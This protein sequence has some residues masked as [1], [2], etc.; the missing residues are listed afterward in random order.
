MAQPNLPYDAL[1][2]P[3]EALA[4]GGTE[5]LRAGII[6][7]ELYVTARRAFKDPAKWG[8]ILADTARRIALLY[9]AEDTDLTEAEVRTEILEA[10]AADLGAK[11][12]EKKPAARHAKPARQ[13]KRA[14]K[15]APA[16]RKSAKRRKR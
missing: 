12:I 1:A 3:D 14:A 8:D 15:R 4:N 13:I 7:G 16:K 2:L 6:D 11:K 5:I 9:S 10:F